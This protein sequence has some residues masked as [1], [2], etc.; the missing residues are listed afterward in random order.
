MCDWCLCGR[1]DFAF[2]LEL[3]FWQCAHSRTVLLEMYDR[4]KDRLSVA[5]NNILSTSVY[6]SACLYRV[7]SKWGYQSCNYFCHHVGSVFHSSL[8]A[9]KQAHTLFCTLSIKNACLHSSSWGRQWGLPLYLL[10]CQ[11]KMTFSPFLF[12][13]QSRIVFW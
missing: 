1:V 9:L 13:A 6:G 3:C 11:S 7:Q 4:R 12:T 8:A 2:H 5:S 10:L